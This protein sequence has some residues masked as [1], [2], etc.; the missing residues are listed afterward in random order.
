GSSHHQFPIDSTA[1]PSYRLVSL[2]DVKLHNLTHLSYGYTQ[3]CISLMR[4]I[5]LA[6]HTRSPTTFSDTFLRGCCSDYIGVQHPDSPERRREL[7]S[8]P[9]NIQRHRV[10]LTEAMPSVRGQESLLCT[11]CDYNN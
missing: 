7:G 3:A 11:Y 4:V 5:Y 2:T 9:A 8:T 10:L 1:R 6:W